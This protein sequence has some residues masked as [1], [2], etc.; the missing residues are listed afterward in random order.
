MLEPGE[1]EF[2][3]VHQLDNGAWAIGDPPSP[4]VLYRSDE[5]PG[6]GP[7]VVTEGEA[8]AD[9]AYYLGFA[10][11]TSA[12]G[13]NSPAKS[14]W[15][16]LAGRD[17]WVLPDND[18]PGERYSQDVVRILI[19]IG[20][21]VRMVHLPD[22]PPGGDIVDFDRDIAAGTET[23]LAEIIRL[24]GEAT[25][26]SLPPAE[27]QPKPDELDAPILPTFASARESVRWKST[28]ESSGD[29]RVIAVAGNRKRH[30]CEQRK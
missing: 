21:R 18:P 14:N 10:A 16:P 26:I 7:I 5:L 23:T 3:P 8:C 11:V 24:A 12:H 28:D 2:R 13:S 9:K 6:D 30:Q 19:G 27:V 4:L 15:T 29:R 17:V 20:C 22:L 25:T 1:K